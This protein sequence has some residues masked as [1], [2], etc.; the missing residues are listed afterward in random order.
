MPNWRVCGP[1][2]CGLLHNLPL[3][4]SSGTNNL[5]LRHRLRSRCPKRI[6]G[7]CGN[8]CRRSMVVAVVLFSQPQAGCVGQ[9]AASLQQANP[10]GGGGRAVPP[11]GSVARG[12]EGAGRRGRCGPPRAVRLEGPVRARGATEVAPS[13]RA[14]AAAP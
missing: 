1:V 14:E 3:N 8:G 2:W 11:C 9:T 5:H 6:G 4:H 7:M 12:G 13:L 10:W